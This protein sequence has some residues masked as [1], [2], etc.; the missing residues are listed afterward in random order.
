[1]KD[2][3]EKLKKWIAKAYNLINLLNKDAINDSL[4][5]ASSLREC[6]LQGKKDGVYEY[7]NAPRE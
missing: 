2:D 7:N 5:I 1:M 4:I 6:Y 3:Y